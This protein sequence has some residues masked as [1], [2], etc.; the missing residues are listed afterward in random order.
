MMENQLNM[1]FNNVIAVDIGNS[2]IKILNDNNFHYFDYQQNWKEKLLRILKGIDNYKQVVYSS[3]NFKI[4]VELLEIL[5]SFKNIDVTEVNTLLQYQKMIDFSEIE[6]IGTDRMLGLIGALGFSGF[7]VITI[8]CGTAIT[9]NVA[10]KGRCL[11]G[12]IFPGQFTQYKS[13]SAIS[14]KLDIKPNAAKSFKIGRNTSQAVNFGVKLSCIGGIEKAIDII[15]KQINIKPANIFLTGGYAHEIKN[16]LNI[17]VIY[18][19]Q[20]VLDGIIH[21]YRDNITTINKIFNY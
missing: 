2:Q 4:E 9:I 5:I 18:K 21:L 6:G 14:N 19:Q 12:F 3:V 16:H 8:D 7:P 17:D 11:G 20:L 15:S 10:D 1:T 13:L